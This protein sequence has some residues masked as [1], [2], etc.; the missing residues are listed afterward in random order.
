MDILDAKDIVSGHI[1]SHGWSNVYVDFQDGQKA[2][3]SYAYSVGF[4]ETFNQ[5][6]VVVFDLPEEN[7]Y[8]VLAS[9]A[10][11][12]DTGWIMEPHIRMANILQKQFDH[13]RLH[14]IFSPLKEEHGLDFDVAENYYG[15][16]FRI[17]AMFW[18]DMQNQLPSENNYS[19]EEQ[20]NALNR[21]QGLFVH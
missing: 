1:Q 8:N 13:K 7:A 5:P 17:L 11:Q 20:I 21:V 10:H 18:P 15:K 9:I 3:G 14:V 6:E 16:P 2:R 19:H 4:E 12:M